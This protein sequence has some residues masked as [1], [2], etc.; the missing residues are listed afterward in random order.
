MRTETLVKLL[1]K[2]SNDI[3]TELFERIIKVRLN[4]QIYVVSHVEHRD[5]IKEDVIVICIDDND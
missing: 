5:E 1:S 4:G 2:T 3:H